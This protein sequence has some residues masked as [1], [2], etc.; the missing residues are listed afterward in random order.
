MF[1]PFTETGSLATDAFLYD[2]FMK[3]LVPLSA[4]SVPHLEDAGRCFFV[5]M[6]SRAVEVVIR[7]RLL[8]APR[9][10]AELCRLTFV[11]VAIQL[12][13]VSLVQLFFIV[14][15]FAKPVV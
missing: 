3:F 15:C 11:D 13:F 5:A 9:S 2:S 4:S 1:N 14:F 6:K 7:L 8:G 12:W 10:S